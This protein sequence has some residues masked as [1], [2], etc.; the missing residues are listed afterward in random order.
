ML[1]FVS[2]QGN[3]NWRTDFLVQHFGE[4]DPKIRG[5]PQLS[6]GVSVCNSS[7]NFNLPD[8]FHKALLSLVSRPSTAMW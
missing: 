1:L 3:A 5:C 4:G 2:I 6:P 7:Q 8:S